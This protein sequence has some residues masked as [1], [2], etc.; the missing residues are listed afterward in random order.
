[1]KTLRIA[2][3]NTESTALNF[4]Q[5]LAKIEKLAIKRGGGF[6]GPPKS[7]MVNEHEDPATGY[8][9]ALQKMKVEALSG[10]L[11]CGRAAS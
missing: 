11:L 5:N 9:S 7:V 1:M 6:P 8:V 3:N 4:G 2:G 10:R